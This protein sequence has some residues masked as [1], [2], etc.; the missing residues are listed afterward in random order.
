MA[1]RKLEP[2]S[3]RIRRLRRLAL[4]DRFDGRASD[5][6]SWWSISPAG[7]L[8][9]VLVSEQWTRCTRELEGYFKAIIGGAVDRSRSMVAHR[10]S[11]PWDPAKGHGQPNKDR[12]LTGASDRV[13]SVRIRHGGALASRGR[14]TQAMGH[15]LLRRD[16]PKGQRTGSGVVF[17]SRPAR[18]RGRPKHCQ[19]MGRREAELRS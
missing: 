9:E 15:S 3:E 4:R 19:A 14:S 16:R 5:Y 11:W 12:S 10:H 18:P 17:A 7:N 2:I 1:I 13:T 8:T 6:R